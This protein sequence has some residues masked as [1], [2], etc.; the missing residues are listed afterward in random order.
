[1]NKYIFTN[2]MKEISG[3]G[4]Q[5]E[6]C[7][8]KMVIAGLEWFDENEGKSPKFIT[9]RGITG[10]CQSDNEDAKELSEVMVKAVAEFGATGAMHQYT[11][12]HVMWIIKNGWDEYVK[13]QIHE[14]GEVGLLKERLARQEEQT[15]TWRENATELSADNDKMKDIIAAE[16]F[17]W[18]KH[19]L[20][21]NVQFAYA[22]TAEAALSI[23]YGG[24]IRSLVTEEIKN[25]FYDQSN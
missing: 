21:N 3:L 24:C 2:D 13:K 22:P 18:Q 12:H 14:G 10:V 15:K 11:V 9:F 5:Y 8:R 19:I 6:E 23:S 1:M 7:C 20:S 17:G 16:I 25:R 4:G